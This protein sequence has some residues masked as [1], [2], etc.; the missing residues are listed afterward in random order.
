M[1]DP[2]VLERMRADWN[3]RAGEDANYY[4]AFGRREQEE[5]EFFATGADVVRGLEMDLA[6]FSG[7]DAAL[8]I[9]CGPGRLMRP[10]SHH[11]KEIHGV[12][13]SDA[14]IKL[15]RERLRGTPNAF[16]HHASGSDLK[17]FPDEKFD[18]VYS[19]AVFQHIPSAEVVFQYLRE[20]RRVL[21][22]GGIL[23][24][25]VNGLPPTAR[26]YDTWA[27]VR[28]APEQITQFALDHD[29]QLLAL[30]MRG[31]Q[32][33]WLTC[34][35]RPTGWV[36]SLATREPELTAVIRSLSN[37]HTGEAVA[38]ASGPMAALSLWVKGLPDECDLN[39]L[40]VTVDG[41]PGRPEYIGVPAN[42]GVQQVN[43]RLPDEV[44]TGVV[45]VEMA[46]LGRRIAAPAWVRIIPPG[47]AVARLESV[48]DGVN[49]LLH[50]RT[51]SGSLK[52]T[53][54]EVPHAEQFHA[55]VDGQPVRETD[56]F[57]TDPILRRYEFNF[58][59]PEGLGKGGHVL[60]LKMGKRTFPPMG[61]EVA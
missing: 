34:R 20:A 29:F 1:D 8:E 13:V 51:E 49:L 55:T 42:D 21:K 61:I 26:Q 43:V 24:C 35:K 60:Q 37:A 36:R 23:R 44:R 11:F 54:M 39:H 17:L 6:R 2:K 16:P 33:M 4:V 28:I 31:T 14:M 7:R 53:M 12:D 32:Y 58:R 10:L 48:T 47:P 5:A 50:Q 41:R 30:E 52:V 40:T 3:E 46:W 19:Y 38:P 57:C 18:F 27:G 9:G 22:T 59:M 56:S 15:A 45:P 25:Q